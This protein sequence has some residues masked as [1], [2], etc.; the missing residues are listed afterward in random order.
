MSKKEDVLHNLSFHK[1]EQGLISYQISNNANG[2]KWK[3]IYVIYNARPEMVKYKLKGDWK[4]AVVGD[5][6][7]LNQVV[8]GKINIPGISMMI[9]YQ[10]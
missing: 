9:L 4:I 8:S 7:N 2:D 5:D 6:F 10:E 3:N 1:V